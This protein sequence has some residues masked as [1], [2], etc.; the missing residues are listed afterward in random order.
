MDTDERY[1][2][3]CTECGHEHYD[4]ASGSYEPCDICTF[5]GGTD[6]PAAEEE[7]K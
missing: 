6:C 5:D 3:G 2:V 1:F 7:T 4:I